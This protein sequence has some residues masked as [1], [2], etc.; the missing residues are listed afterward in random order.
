MPDMQNLQ[1]M[2]KDEA[3]HL[4]NAR[5]YLSA[6]QKRKALKDQIRVLES[7]LSGIET[8]RQARGSDLA[9]TVGPNV[10]RRCFRLD[11]STLVI[12][13]S[14]SKKTYAVLFDDKGRLVSSEAI[15]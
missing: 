10:T 5:D 1:T 2:T 7:E 6:A 15:G 4:T 12:E 13:Y 9:T 8:H 14:E 11:E 3:R